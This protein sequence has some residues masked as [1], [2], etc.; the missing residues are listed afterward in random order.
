M[1]DDIKVT[2]VIN[3]EGQAVIKND[4]EQENE[5]LKQELREAYR[6]IVEL[7]EEKAGLQRQNDSLMTELDEYHQAVK[8]LVFGT[9]E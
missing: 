7:A 6:A 1:K 8:M 3:E 5:E 4:L 9:E 2:L